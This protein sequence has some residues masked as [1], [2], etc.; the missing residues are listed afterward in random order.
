MRAVARRWWVAALPAAMAAMGLAGC[1]S[2]G[3]GG[4]APPQLQFGLQDAGLAATARRSAPLVDAL[5]VQSRPGDALADTLG[6]AYSRREGEYAFYQLAS[7]TERPVRQLPRLLQRR[8][9]ARGV[10]ATVGLAGDPMRSDWLLMLGVDAIHHDLRTAPGAARLALTAELFDRRTR[11]RVAL[12]RFEASEPSARA[13]SSAA[14]QAMSV[15][16]GR[17]F[18]ELVPWLEA[19]LALAAR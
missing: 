17:A 4:D 14:S 8:L 6:I 13:D 1:V 7:W 2:V 16:L 12:R 9:D 10:A 5:L 19:Q 3:V 18:D 15:A 11:T